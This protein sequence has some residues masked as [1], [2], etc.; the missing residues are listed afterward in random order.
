MPL[1]RLRRAGG[2]PFIAS[3]IP[4][5]DLLHVQDAKQTEI[6]PIRYEP[7]SPFKYNNFVYRLS[8][9][10]EATD[11]RRGLKQRPG[12]V[13]IPAGTR[14]FILRLSNPDAEGMHREAR[15]QKEVAILALASA[16]HGHIKPSV[17]PRV[18]GRGD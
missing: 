14:E 2:E 15:V 12:C 9:P 16:A 3:Q 18:Y 4:I 11:E 5:S 6:T 17:V 7:D 8:L 1:R 10:A 13:P